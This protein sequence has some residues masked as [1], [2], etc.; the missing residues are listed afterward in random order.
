MADR[1]KPKRARTSRESERSFRALV[2]H[3]SDIFMILTEDLTIRFLSP[4]VERHLGYRPAEILGRSSFDF[5]HPED[6]AHVQALVA[7]VLNPSGSVGPAEVRV[8][9]ADGSWVSLEVV[10]KNLLGD[11]SVR[12]LI[13]NARDIS[14]RKATEEALRKSEAWL[15]AV[16]THAPVILVAL[17]QEGR[18]TLAEGRGLEALGMK[19]EQL[20]GQTIFDL[21]GGQTSEIVGIFRRALRGEVLTSKVE[22]A[23]RVFEAHS[24]PL[25]DE[26]GRTLGVIGISTDI[27]ERE[28]AEREKE[29]LL[30]VARDISGTVDLDEILDRVQRRTAELLPCERLATF[31]WDPETDMLRLVAQHGMPPEALE[32][33]PVRGFPVS[34]QRM[35][36]VAEM[37]TLVIN[38]VERGPIAAEILKQFGVASLLGTPIVVRGKP[39]GAF[40]ATNVRGTDR[41]NPSQV[42]LF[43]GIAGQV[44]VAIGAAESYRKQ[45]EDAEVAGALAR[46]GQEVISHLSSPTLLSRVCQ[47][48]TE[49]LGCDSSHTLLW[50]PEEQAY[51]VASGYGDPPEQWESLKVL[52]IPQRVIDELAR[53]LG[54][55]EVVQLS[56]LEESE[57]PVLR[58]A[59][60]Q[61]ITVA[62]YVALRRGDEMIGFQAAHYRGR[63]EPFTRQQERIAKGIAHLTSLAL[64]N[65]RLLEELQNA[66]RI[67][68]DFVA[69]MSHELRSPLNVVIGYQD[70]LLEGEF[71]ELST[72]QAD[73]LR[74]ANRSARELLD[75]VAATLD[76][77]RL[78]AKRLQID[79][80]AVDPAQVVEQLVREIGPPPEKQGVQL[81]WEVPEG[82]PVFHTDLVKLRMVLKN[83]IDNAIKFTD[84]GLVLVRA[85][86]CDGA[87]EFSVDD[88]GLGIPPEDRDKIFDAFHQGNHSG[89]SRGGV[90]LGLYIV[91][92]LVDALGGTIA[93]SSRL[94]T[95]SSFR[96][97]VPAQLARP[98]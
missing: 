50:I 30:A 94:G 28:R 72:E 92:R 83:L 73:T 14:E 69:N 55:Q 38:D 78:E 11:P 16:A 23:G 68:S 98:A 71:G 44:A 3:S 97:R 24:S 59:R 80:E 31:M 25:C 61:G 19:G 66:N 4:S 53:D 87:I 60:L 89:N 35:Q 20:V 29:A 7:E 22:F 18:F 47:L 57:L 46:V 40:F 56:M 85:S 17:D 42:K 70:L 91:R 82:L 1:R 37:G 5:I 58:M 67:K 10:A 75:L 27:T 32:R 79:L 93:V 8:R 49:V 6:V 12:G 76:L 15:R 62:L 77:S 84:R 39:I 33:L 90:G 51:V 2:E 9:H 45:R 34:A 81:K 36:E 41:F 64:E 52:K 48:T 65:A 74:R 13:V 95:G 26:S 21:Y 88:T 54:N 43:E 96:V 86:V 63:T